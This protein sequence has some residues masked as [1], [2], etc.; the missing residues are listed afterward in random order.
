[1]SENRKQE[2]AILVGINLDTR[3][4][5]DSEESLQELR[6]LSN[7]AG[8]VE[9]E[10][11]MFPL[12]QIA[13]GTYLRAGN[14]ELIKNK[15]AELK[16][17]LVIFD[18]P[19]SPIQN[20]NLEEAICARVIDR[21][22]LIL[23]IFAIHAH[24]KEGKLQVELAQYEYLYPRLVGM[25]G[26]L[27]K[28]RGGS[29]GLRGPGETQLEVDR[30]RAKERLTKIKYLLKKVTTSRK[31]HRDKRNAI[32]IPII[33]LV[34]YTNAGKST[35]FNALT[36]SAQLVADQLFAT[37]DPKTTKIKLPSGRAVLLTDTVGFIRNLPHQLVE[38]FKSTF[39]EARSSTLLLHVI[40]SASP[41]WSHQME[42][43][44]Q[45]LT[46]LK[47]NEIPCIRVM[48]KCDLSEAPDD[49]SFLKVKDSKTI[50]SV[51]GQTGLGLE[52][53][54]QQI[55]ETLSNQR[56]VIKLLL[57]HPYGSL[58]SGLYQHGRVVS[59]VP[60]EKGIEVSVCLNEK[61]RSK[62]SQYMSPISPL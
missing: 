1:M 16:A 42:V 58:L 40:D 30:R 10:V 57:P 31:L 46:E 11:C 41:T 6:Q 13:P 12:R 43:V 24:S 38:S 53:L 27:S 49:F 2:R 23:D 4:K 51:S 33:T 32:P 60:V 52:N 22:S 7:T 36:S 14:V 59:A 62:Y 26:H 45:V 8:V 56:D 47:L 20:R 34:G 5:A 18:A 29:V 61:W 15:V 48:N 44:D 25:W 35:L 9:L 3:V 54:L 28:Q 17:T 37:L 55:E 50:V 21:T 39:E 19:L